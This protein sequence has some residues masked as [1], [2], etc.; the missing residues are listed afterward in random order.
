MSGGRWL[1]AYPCSSSLVLEV[2]LRDKYC[3]CESR[4]S[5]GFSRIPPSNTY[6]IFSTAGRTVSNCGA[7]HARS[8]VA[9]LPRTVRTL[10]GAVRWRSSVSP[11]EKQC[12]CPSA[13][14][15]RPGK[16]L[17]RLS[18]SGCAT[19]E[20]WE[21]RSGSHPDNGGRGARFI[22]AR[23]REG[24]QDSQP[25]FLSHKGLKQHSR[26]TGLQSYLRR[27]P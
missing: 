3:C 7:C 13:Q 24:M 27:G 18:H 23:A 9:E 21:P 26:S 8:Q 6:L 25:V 11:M 12:G 17:L 16:Q 10:C 4:G 20:P 2:T 22:L 14:A 15:K 5:D 1:S 19:V